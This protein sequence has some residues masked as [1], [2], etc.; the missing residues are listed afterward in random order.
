MIKAISAL[1]FVVSIGAIVGVGVTRP[2]PA[3]E[4]V[5]NPVDAGEVAAGST[6][7]VR[8]RLRNHAAE[9]ILL[10]EVGSSCDCVRG[11]TA[12]PAHIE[13]GGELEIPFRWTVPTKFGEA[14]TSVVIR[15]RLSSSE[16]AHVQPVVLKGVVK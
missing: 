6:A 15:Y 10:E 1:L 14:A 16:T 3:L 11:A 13:A 4:V 9:R 7:D 5:A 8:L 2:V 12:T